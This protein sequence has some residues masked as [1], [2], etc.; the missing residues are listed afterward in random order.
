MSHFS[1]IVF[2]NNP[3]ELESKMAPYHQ[4]ECTGI[5]DQYVNDYDITEEALNQ[6][7]TRTDSFKNMSEIAYVEEWYG[8]RILKYGDKLD[9]KEKHKY[10]YILLKQD[11]NI[12][13]VID[14]TNK[15]RKW[16]WYSF[17][18][19]WHNYFLP[20]EDSSS[21]VIGQPSLVCKSSSDSELDDNWVDGLQ[22]KNLNYTEMRNIRLKEANALYDKYEKIVDN[23]EVPTFKSISMKC[24]NIEDARKEYWSNPIIQRLN[25]DEDLRW[26]VFD[27]KYLNLSRED[28]LQEICDSVLV[29][30]SFIDLDGNWHER[31]QM[32]SF[33]LSSNE[34]LPIDWATEFWD[35]LKSVPDTTYMMIV[36]CHI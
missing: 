11:G 21:N 26:W 19:R 6:F 20:Y 25:A 24:E 12:D 18:G 13:K 5:D 31:A 10:G 17:G 7:K 4:F 28:Y 34:K 1:C 35:Y 23:K 14:R 36:D 9:L 22:I 2:C 27:G 15:N 8:H 30:Y 16:D 32:G 29:P 33:A 3:S